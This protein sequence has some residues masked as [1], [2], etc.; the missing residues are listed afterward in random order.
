MK[1]FWHSPPQCQL[2][3]KRRVGRA[4]SQT[5]SSRTATVH[6]CRGNI[7]PLIWKTRKKDNREETTKGQ[8]LINLGLW[9]EGQERK[10]T[11]VERTHRYSVEVKAL[12]SLSHGCCLFLVMITPTVG[13][14]GGWKGSV[15]MFQPAYCHYAWMNNLTIITLLF[16]VATKT[17]R[18]QLST[19]A[20]LKKQKMCVILNDTPRVCR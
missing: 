6:M 12:H 7:Y 17:S 16:F 9:E 11:R 5:A 4:I 2:Y 20:T 18:W 8:W 1:L 13:G 3:I 14:V 19:I 15:D 10:K